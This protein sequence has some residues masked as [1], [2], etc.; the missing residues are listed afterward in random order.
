LWGI[1]QTG[2]ERLV[3]TR[4]LLETCREWACQA[5]VC[6]S[7]ITSK[8]SFLQFVRSDV[9]GPV[10]NFAPAG[11]VIDHDGEG[12]QGGTG[13]QP[14][15]TTRTCYTPAANHDI[16]S[17]ASCHP[18]PPLWRNRVS[19]PSISN[20]RRDGSNGSIDP[21]RRGYDA[22]NMSM[23]ATADAAPGHPVSRADSLPMAT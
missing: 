8:N 20:R 21:V 23:A 7:Q 15:Y 10:S 11:P 9:P 22:T 14:T 16:T 4:A 1:C 17:H 6:L 3:E 18:L 2:N 12:G 5:R 13:R 19:V